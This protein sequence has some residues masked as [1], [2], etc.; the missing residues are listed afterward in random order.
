[1][2]QL[3]VVICPDYEL[4]L[5]DRC[6]RLIRDLLSDGSDNDYSYTFESSAV[7]HMKLLFTRPELSKRKRREGD[8]TDCATE[9]T[10]DTSK[11]SS[12]VELTDK[13][14]KLLSLTSNS[15]HYSGNAQQSRG[16]PDSFSI[17]PLF[18][19]TS[20]VIDKHSTFDSEHME[21]IISSAIQTMLPAKLRSLNV[22]NPDYRIKFHC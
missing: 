15:V 12:P 17:L 5:T 18:S 22:G 2:R 9:S 7:C 3:D 19:K 1:V 11:A 14:L 21:H 8:T 13:N 6:Q 4:F 10:I 16:S 20:Q